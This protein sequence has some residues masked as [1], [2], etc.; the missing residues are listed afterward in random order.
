[1]VEGYTQYVYGLLCPLSRKIRYVGLTRKPVERYD[2]HVKGQPTG[3]PQKQRWLLEL[4]D[5]GL[6]PE[7]LIFEEAPAEQVDGPFVSYEVDPRELERRWITRL[8][9]AGHPLTNAHKRQERRPRED[10]FVAE[11]TKRGRALAGVL[12]VDPAELID[13]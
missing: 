10:R 4:R 5:K 12:D 7:F 1:V 8:T 9:E 11:A 2:Q 13:E 3:T 6:V